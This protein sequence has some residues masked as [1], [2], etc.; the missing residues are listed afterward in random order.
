[1]LVDA[2]ACMANADWLYVIP[3]SR[4]P[5]RYFLLPLEMHGNEMVKLIDWGRSRIFL[6]DNAK[7]RDERLRYDFQLLL[8]GHLPERKFH[9]PLKT[10]PCE[11]RLGESVY[12]GCARLSVRQ[13]V[14][15][16][17]A[18]RRLC[19]PTVNVMQEWPSWWA[20]VVR[21]PFSSLVEA[22]LASRRRVVLAGSGQECTCAGDG[23]G[24]ASRTCTDVCQALASG[25]LAQAEQA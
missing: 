18:A 12:V 8:H 7:E 19:D 17:R 9:E 20:N 3:A 15:L 24:D 5:P 14:G 21:G 22:L 23:G 13:R 16:L 4:G 25:L 1:M 2:P 10:L 11:F 6:T